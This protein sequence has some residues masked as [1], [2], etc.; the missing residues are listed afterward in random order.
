MV[1]ILVSPSKQEFSM[2]NDVG[3]L[4]VGGVA[5]PN[6]FRSRTKQGIICDSIATCLIFE[7]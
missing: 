1:M 6:E 5:V 7:T 2:G 3:K 4:V